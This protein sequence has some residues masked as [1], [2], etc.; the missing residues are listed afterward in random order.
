VCF[1]G[2]ICVCQNQY[3]DTYYIMADS[4]L[5]HISLTTTWTCN[6]HYVDFFFW[7]VSWICLRNH[8]YIYIH[9]YIFPI[10]SP[11]SGF[12]I[13][14][15]KDHL[16]KIQGLVPFTPFTTDLHHHSKCATRN[17]CGV[18]LRSAMLLWST[19]S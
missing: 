2:K 14:K 8:Q 9:I 5:L 7:L 16:Q 3:M 15:I 18:S 1:P 19:T 17:L 13:E 11:S 4:V 6:F 12:T 10:D